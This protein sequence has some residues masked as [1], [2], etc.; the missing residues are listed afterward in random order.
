ME[1]GL[2]WTGA[3]TW[4][5]GL[6]APPVEFPV[7]EVI[8]EEIRIQQVLES[9]SLEGD[10]SPEAILKRYQAARETVRAT[11]IPADFDIQAELQRFY[12]SLS[13]TSRI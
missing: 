5:K 6:V 1:H 10:E 9:Q 12:D 13:G 2:D 4:D 8:I 11:P 7:T 3:D